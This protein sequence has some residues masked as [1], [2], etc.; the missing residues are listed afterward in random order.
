[1]ASD[2][3]S[4]YR[5]LCRENGW[6]PD[7][8]QEAA[9]IRLSEIEEEALAPKGFLSRF[10]KRADHDQGLYLYGGVGRGKSFIMDFYFSRTPIA[11]KWRVHF[12]EFMQNVHD[13]MHEKRK[14]GRNADTGAFLMDYAAQISNQYQLICFDEMFVDDVADAMLLGR[15]FTALIEEG[16]IIIMTSNIAPENLYK[17]GLQRERFVPFIDLITQR[18]TTIHFTGQVDYRAG[19]LHAFKRYLHPISAETTNQIDQTFQGALNGQTPAPTTIE[20]KGRQIR[21]DAAKDDA[22]CTD[23][24]TLCGQALGAGDYLAIAKN[25]HTVFLEHVPVMK[26]DRRNEAKRMMTLVDALYEQKTKLIVTADAPPEKLYLGQ[27][28][29]FEFERTV[30]RLIEMQG[31]EYLAEAG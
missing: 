15:L 16:V 5:A 24:D 23:F 9:L 18:F 6:Q 20:I 2:T 19:K 28:H 13:A 31:E 10:R 17:D 30:S 29:S 7:P 14:T 22:L 8:N 21:F 11:K 3:L 1:M 4:D 26:Y 27:D 25:Y 12:H